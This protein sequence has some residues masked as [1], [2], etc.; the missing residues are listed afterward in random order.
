MPQ[1]VTPGGRKTISA[2]D[3]A[4]YEITFISAIRGIRG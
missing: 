3:A 1:L 2:A 4:D